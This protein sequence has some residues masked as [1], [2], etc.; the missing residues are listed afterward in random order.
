MCVTE[1]D[2]N[3]CAL[4]A[5]A[6]AAAV[7]EDAFLSGGGIGLTGRRRWWPAR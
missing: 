7:V 2:H 5:A 6:A 4:H 1:V 3:P